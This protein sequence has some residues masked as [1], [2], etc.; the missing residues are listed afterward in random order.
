M[1][2]YNWGHSK[3]HAKKIAQI[4][5]D[6]NLPIWMD[7]EGGMA[8]GNIYAAMA[9]GVDKAKAVICLVSKNYS[10]S[11]NCKKE[12]CTAASQ[13]KIILPCLVDDDYAGQGG[14]LG[15]IIAGELYFDFRKG[16]N[17]GEGLIRSIYKQLKIEPQNVVANTP[18]KLESSEKQ[19][20]QEEIFD[21][22]FKGRVYHYYNKGSESTVVI[23][24]L[25]A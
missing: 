23:F 17:E 25:I 5:K 9:E 7:I 18:I 20:S 22:N 4:L 24:I 19:L 16:K 21:K 13:N 11:V 12:L 1:I 8:G 15:L 14:W 2:S 3:D 6:H 10:E